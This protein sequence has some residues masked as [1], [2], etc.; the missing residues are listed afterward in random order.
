MIAPAKPSPRERDARAS[1][2]RF[3]EML[4][5]IRRYARMAFQDRDPEARGEKVQ[6]TIANAFVAFCRLVKQ[7]K[8]DLAYPTPLAMYAIR[9][10]KPGRH[11]GSKLNVCDVSST[12]RQLRKGVHVL[13]LDH[14]DKDAQEWKE[15]LIE[16]H[17]AGPAEIVAVRIDF[18]A[19]GLNQLGPAEFR[20][21][22]VFGQLPMPDFEDSVAGTVAASPVSTARSICPTRA[23]K[24]R[25][26]ASA[27]ATDAR[28]REQAVPSGHPEN[29]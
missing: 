16:D 1:N 3:L 20:R 21:L 26:E 9:Q 14:F 7:G 23:S 25:L 27:G 28:M 12:H 17:R 8:G 19:W 18:G 5:V 22:P 15:I 13:R 2:E 10:V 6:E 4:P 29:R 11:V 24:V